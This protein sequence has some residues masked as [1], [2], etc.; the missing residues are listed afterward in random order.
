[1]KAILFDMDGVIYNSETLIEGAPEALAW[2]RSQGIP[3]LFVT[4][5]T[6]RSRS[7]LAEKLTRF[8]IPAAEESIL[9]PRIF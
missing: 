2:V 8:G 6:S 3:H 4:N 5:T 1:M 7:I 9:T